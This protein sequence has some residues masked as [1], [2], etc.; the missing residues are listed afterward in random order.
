MGSKGARA[1]IIGRCR[2]IEDGN[3]AQAGKGSGRGDSESGVKGDIV[4]QDDRL[5]VTG[6]IVSSS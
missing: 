4:G 3:G 1:V 6:R 5:E 2:G